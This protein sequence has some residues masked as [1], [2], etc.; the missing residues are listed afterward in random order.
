MTTAPAT[1]EPLPPIRNMKIAMPQNWIGFVATLH[2]MR[3][4]PLGDFTPVRT[5]EPDCPKT[6]RVGGTRFYCTDGSNMFLLDEARQPDGAGGD[7]RIYK[8]GT[9]WIRAARSQPVQSPLGW[10][11]VMGRPLFWLHDNFVLPGHIAAWV[12]WRHRDT[13]TIWRADGPG[14]DNAAIPG[15]VWTTED[16]SAPAL[17]YLM[18]FRSD[19]YPRWSELHHD[20]R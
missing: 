12:L 3:Q 1:P 13:G 5:P 19:N 7:K 15:G 2:E 14:N 6:V 20:A 11:L 10:W 18:P 4:H 17:A 8:P 16:A 9:D